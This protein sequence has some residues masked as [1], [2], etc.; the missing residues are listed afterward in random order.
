MKKTLTLVMLATIA[1]ASSLFAQEKN[2][3]VIDRV[4]PSAESFNSALGSDRYTIDS[5]AITSGSFY[6]EFFYLIKDCCEKG[7]LTGIDMSRTHYFWSYIPAHAFAPTIINGKPAKSGSDTKKDPTRTDLRYFTLPT[8]IGKI[9]DMAFAWTNLE[10]ITIPS[11]THLGNGAFSGCEKLKDVYIIGGRDKSEEV[12]AAFSGLPE[13]AVLHV[14]KGLGALYDTELIRNTFS[15]VR[16]DDGLYNVMD[17]TLDGSRTLEEMMQGQVMLVDSM[18]LSGPVTEADIDYLRDNGCWFGRLKN[19]DLSDCVIECK[20]GW[21]GCRF[22][23]LR[24]PKQM[25]K[26]TYCFLEES[27]VNNLTMPESYEEIAVAAFEKYKWFAD[28][29][30]IIPEGCRKLAYH[31]FCYCTSI[32]TLFLPSTLEILEP[33]SL[34]FSLWREW[35]GLEADIY[36]NRMYPPTSTQTREDD[37]NDPEVDSASENGPFGCQEH[38]K[39]TAGCLTRNMRLFVPVGAK[40]NY[41]TAEHWDHFRTIIETPML[42]GT[43]DGIVETV[44]SVKPAA[45]AADGIYTVDGRLVTRDMAAKGRL[46]GLYIVREGGLTRKVTF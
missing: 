28:S 25:K 26:I 21:F 13:G 32:K 4:E 5:L 22:D 35:E 40:K 23:Y 46:R 45:S 19:L 30:L 14:A 2:I 16:E 3:K 36:V 9:E 12:E 33:S 7:R 31:A 29:T 41:E 15:E 11:I 10:T 42:T 17:I 6:P 37:V 18:T 34:G 8:S 43:P 27:A 44:M 39:G 24:M 20:N 1:T 38:Y